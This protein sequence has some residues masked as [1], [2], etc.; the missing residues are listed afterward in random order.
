MRPDLR[1]QP[2]PARLT[3]TAQHWGAY[4][5][6]S[7][8]GRVSELRPVRDDPDPSPIGPGM[9]RALDDASRVQ[10]PSVR[11][12]WLQN[13]PRESRSLRGA[14]PFVPVSWETALE[15]VAGELT[16]VR[17]EHGDASVY[18]GSY[19]WA[20]A[21]RFHHA[22]SQ[23]HRFLA[24]GGGYVDSVNSYSC[25]A[26]EVV[27]PHVIGGG[28]WRIFE[29][30]PQWTEIAEHGQLVVAFG[31]AP[32]KNSQINSGGLSRH[33]SR[34]L[35]RRCRD[36]GVRFVNVSPTRDALDANL[37]A[38][39]LAP[40]PNTDVA[41]MLG[42]AHTI[43][44]DDAHDRDFLDRCC[45]G[46]DR[47]VEYVVGHTDGIAKDAA[48]ASAITG[49]PAPTIR[50]LAREIVAQRTLITV[51]WSIQRADHG[52]LTYW[53]A[54]ALAAMSGSMGRPGGGFGAGYSAEDSLG[55]RSAR[56]AVAA[57]SRVKNRVEEFIPVA[58]IADM[59][60]GPG[61][62]FCYNGRRL[63]YP[64]IRLIYWCGG[65]PFHHHQDLNRLVQAWRRPE[66][67]IMHDA[68]WN[69]TARFADV[70]L[71]CTTS[72]ERTDIACGSRDP[73]LMALDRCADP[74]PGARDD[75]AIFADLAERSGFGK[76]FTEGRSADEWVEHLYQRSRISLR[77]LGVELPEYADFRRIG[78]VEI[79]GPAQRPMPD[80]AAIRADP[81]SH[82]FATPSGRIELFS[83]RIA[84]FDY[85]DCPGLPVWLEPTEW[86]GAP[87]ADRFPLHLISTQPATR[88][89]SQYDNGAYSQS[90]KVN[91]REPIT[92][93]E[94]DARERGI[95][96]GDVVIVFNDRG[97][98][99]A[100]A[101]LTTG[102]RRRVVELSTGAW[103]S[104]L[105]PGTIG[106][107]DVHGNPNVLTLDKGTSQLAQGPSAQT[108]LVQVE[109]YEGALPLVRAFDAPQ[110][111]GDAV[112]ESD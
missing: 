46:A 74:P 94:D 4:D 102:I 11:L 95:A 84:S 88:L 60:L 109:R 18:G 104:P 69:A 52:E 96:D 14:E 2:A 37:E 75:Y 83:S 106:S 43:I 12:G 81:T 78:R 86:L 31:G 76:A 45:E 1:G 15:L 42:L 66:T 16:R 91:G 85:D 87:L 90:S 65:N 17:R 36:A 38:R 35:Q 9:V 56:H 100:G 68:W 107:L 22:Q 50:D 29:I 55:S 80:F 25:A 13:G 20:S 58:R 54:I 39:W 8:N 33:Q 105:E 98:C 97:A 92:M 44:S 64:D 61:E 48:W 41:L 30:S 72:L 71:P 79:G 49:L 99:L 6:V 51:S 103:Y 112:A 57:L 19:G 5:V 93:H 110:F 73:W 77:E 59:L 26:L 63:T 21:G 32:L 24:L 62:P 3:R 101:R 67:I 89:H 23:I 70:V 7:E 34:G 111:T 10:W 28:P 40:I 53:M 27:M 82:P 108:C 47:L